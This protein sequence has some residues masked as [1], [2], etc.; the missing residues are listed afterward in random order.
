MSLNIV[1]GMVIDRMRQVCV[2]VYPALYSTDIIPA[3]RP[4]TPDPYQLS[5]I[6]QLPGRRLFFPSSVYTCP[7][8][9]QQ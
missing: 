4:A 6:R 2:S 7:E 3:V 5:A 8:L 1:T 9:F